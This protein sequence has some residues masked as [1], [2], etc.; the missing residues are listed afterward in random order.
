LKISYNCVS[1]KQIAFT[2]GQKWWGSHLHPAEC[3]KCGA[4]SAVPPSSSQAYFC[5]SLVAAVIVSVIS[6]AKGM[7]WLGV[8]VWPFAIGLYLMGWHFAKMW[9]VSRSYASNQR[10]VHWAMALAY[11]LFSPFQ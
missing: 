5:F 9:P 3:P 4:T 1:C 2:F 8:L 7:V 11:V 6:F 10:K